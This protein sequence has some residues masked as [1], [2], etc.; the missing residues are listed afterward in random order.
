MTVPF[1]TTEV[2]FT[3]PVW[4]DIS[5]YVRSA[6][7]TRGST[8]VDS[9]TIRYEAGTAELTLDNRD[10]RFDP[11]NLSGPYTASFSTDTGTY[12]FNCTISQFYGLGITLN[13]KSAAGQVASVVNVS[14]R[15]SGTTSSFTVPK[16]SGTVSGHKMILIHF[17]DAGDVTDSTASGGATWNGLTSYTLGTDTI[18][19]RVYHK[20][21]GGSEPTNYTVG[22]SAGTD[23]VAIVIAIAN[24]D[25]AVTPTFNAVD[26]SG[27]SLFTA[28]GQAPIGSADLDIRACGGSPWGL[29][30]S[31]WLVDDPLAGFA[32]YA[33]KQSNVYTS[34]AVWIRSLSGVT[35]GGGSATRVL[36]V[37][38]VRIRATWSFT[39]TTNLIQNP[40]FETGTTGWTDSNGNGTIAVRDQ[41]G[42]IG[43]DSLQLSRL[44]T[45]GSFLYGATCQGVGSGGATSGQTV[46]I[47]AYVY[48][49]SESFSK[50]TGYSITAVGVTSTFV[51]GPSSADGWYRISLT[52]VLT[53]TLDDVQIQ[54][55]TNDTH[56]DGQVIAYIDGVQA[57]V[58]SSAS[59]YCDGDQPGCTWAG[60]EHNS[61]SSRPAS[62]TFPLFRGFVDNWNIA[63]TA[64]VDSE[65][66][67][68]CTDGFKLL[69]A[70][71][72]AALGAPVGANELS[73]ARVT[74]ILDSAD[75][76]VADRNIA[77]G[78]SQMQGTTLDGAALT[79]LFLTADSELGEF[80]LDAA[81]TAT[82]RG[83]TG[84]LND[85]RSTNPQARFGDGGSIAGE[86]MYL[87]V[88][89]SN[90]DTQLYNEARVAR[91]GGSQQTAF[92]QDSIDDFLIHTFERTDLTLVSDSE[93]LAYAQWIVYISK[94]P[95]LKFDKLII[96]PQ[97]DEENLF[98]Q[99]LDRE[100]GDRVRIT[101]RPPDTTKPNNQGDPVTREVFVRGVEFDIEV[102]NWTVTYTLQ[103]ATKVGSF[104]TLNHPVLGRIGRNALRF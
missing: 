51:T 18:Q 46:T 23:G 55:W 16:P 99:V 6:K 21:A 75:W 17:F 13:I 100:I 42:W 90:D 84:I 39:A 88:E 50:I 27:N 45:S 10:R 15:A 4:T 22:Q 2:M 33:D 62:V 7:I 60:T 44:Q 81:G 94:D 70:V 38:P 96:K 76:P 53:A 34:A 14:S 66:T 87:D 61:N 71:D 36:P 73:G 28:A 12:K 3:D 35:I 9:P 47:S 59:P 67:V 8:R 103:S 92:D 91:T 43:G 1:L 5:P 37:R 57:E 101:R 29:G 49:P 24:A 83:R 52:K 102:Y 79:E 72:R 74:R 98:P 31:S 69:G 97:K 54:F 85:T 89:I 93:A 104:L 56:S 77:T 64:D 68:P 82:F 19:A 48:V 58:R 20:T 63:W 95:E 25:N 41:F 30:G 65:V 80:Y 32:E 86:L 78:S 26:N 11:T 40:S